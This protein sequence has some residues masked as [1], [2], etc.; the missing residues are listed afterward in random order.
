MQFS[1]LLSISLLVLG[2]SAQISGPNGKRFCAGAAISCQ[3]KKGRCANACRDTANDFQNGNAPVA[4]IY[5]TVCSCPDGQP[6]NEYTGAAC[7]DLIRW[8]QRHKC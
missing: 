8:A 5:D 2:A 6:G 3:Y 4:P 1:T 7:I